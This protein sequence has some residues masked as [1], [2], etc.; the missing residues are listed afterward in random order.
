MIIDCDLLTLR[1]RVRS[2]VI[3]L[4]A[5]ASALGHADCIQE[6]EMTR[7]RLDSRSF[8]LLFY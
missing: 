4:Q 6:L 8:R 5:I 7:A 3:E 1:N 2:V